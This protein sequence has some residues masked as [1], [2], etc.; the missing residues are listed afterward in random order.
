MYLR[1]PKRYRKGRHREL[2]LFSGRKL[3]TLV[4]ILVAGYA[5][6][7]IWE[8]QGEVRSS[9]VPIFDEV[10]QGIQTQVAPR[11][12]L[13][14]TPDLAA[15]EIN[16]QNMLRQGSLQ[17][18]LSQCRVLAEGRPNDAKLH[19]QVTHMLIITSNMGADLDRMTEALQFAEKTINANPEAPYGWAIRAMA[20]DWKGE[21]GPA[22]A[23]GLH[24][25]ALDEQFGP[26][27]AF[28]G[29]IY[30]D[31]GQ[32]DVAESYLQKALELDT[33]GLAVADAFRNQG[34]LFSRQGYY[35]DAIQPYQAA[36]QNAPNY[37]YVAA[38]LALNYS[39]LGEAEKAVEVL[40]ST[41]ERNPS[42][43]LLLFELGRIYVRT[44]NPERAYEYYNRC[45]DIDKD[46][47]FCLSFLGRLQRDDGDYA[48]AA[49]NLERAIAL[50]SSSD[51]DFYYLGEVYSAMDRCDRAIP[52]LQQGYQIALQTEDVQS[53]SKFVTQ[54][55]SCGVLITQSSESTGTGSTQ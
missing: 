25:K 34:L 15:A 17:E 45:L 24:A 5:G 23:S 36:L 19:F 42:D 9:V 20:L 28:L 14:A 18:A 21:Y 53:Q 48:S 30:Q 41:L 26:T 11:P 1:T 44:G 33:A 52:Y 12:T 8:N 6:W 35:E 43:P 7:L 2:R 37:S 3:L 16:C 38:E 10:A 50:G 29:E 40:S 27:Y 32:Y 46:N 22:L 55:Q 47:R 4:V 49:S 51:D 54:L 31:L 39:Q 13:T